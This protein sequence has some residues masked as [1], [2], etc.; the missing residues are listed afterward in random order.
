MPLT[1]ADIARLIPHAGTMCLLDGVVAWDDASIRCTAISHRAPDNPLLDG[2]RLA[3]V[4]G[5]EY[6]AQAMAVHGGL[7]GGGKRPAAGYLASVRDLTCHVGRLDDVAE[8]L[9]IEADRL[10]GEGSS[11]IYSFMVRA[12]GRELLSGRAAV[13]IDA[14]VP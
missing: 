6:A 13:V 8:D 10:M 9:I 2:G 12:G 4:C 14:G 1:K 5:V 7:A 3:A 11:V